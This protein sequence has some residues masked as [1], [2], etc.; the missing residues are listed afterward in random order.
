MAQRLISV[1]DAIARVTPLRGRNLRQERITAGITNINWRIH[2]TDTGEIFFLKIHGSGTDNFLDRPVAHEAALKVAQSGVG[3]AMLF[4]DPEAGIEMHEYLHGYRSCTV[5]DTQDPVIRQNIMACY[6]AVHSAHVLSGTKTGFDQLKGHLI[7]LRAQGAVFPPDME[8]LLWH[9]ARA[10]R[11]VT[12]A[13]MDVVACYNDGYISNYM[14]NAQSAVKMIDWE[15]AANNDP[16]WDIAMFSYESFFLGDAAVSGL[17]EMY[18]GTAR[19]DLV[20]RVSLYIGVASLTWG[21]WAM[22]QMLNSS[23]PFDFGKYADIL[24][25]R[26]R[27]AMAAEAWETALA[28]V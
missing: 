12:A 15:Y 1:A 14:V 4:Y 13:G 2:D 6:K 18:D 19:A 16:Y 27:R 10:E 17:L 25:L 26:A 9:A 21:C 28:R 8:L 7:R 24:F 23:I 3:P 5:R 11:A 20:A 22:Y